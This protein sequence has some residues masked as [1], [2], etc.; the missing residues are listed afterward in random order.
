MLRKKGANASAK[1]SAFSHFLMHLQ[2]FLHLVIL[3]ISKGHTTAWF[4]WLL[5]QKVELVK[6]YH[7]TGTCERACFFMHNI[8]GSGENDH[9]NPILYKSEKKVSSE[10]SSPKY[11]NE[12]I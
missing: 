10:L 7:N 4:I 5:T 6:R 8:F 3:Y 1:L 2:N 12:Q 9:I 11:F